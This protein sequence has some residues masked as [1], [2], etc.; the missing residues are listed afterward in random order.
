MQTNGGYYRLLISGK[1]RIKANRNQTKRQMQCE[2]QL[3][4]KP[5][6]SQGVLQLRPVK[7]FHRDASQVG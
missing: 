2:L 3:A 1:Q 4:K 5:K 6:I 7:G